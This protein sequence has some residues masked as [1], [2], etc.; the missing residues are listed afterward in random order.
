MDILDK[1][2]KNEESLPT[3]LIGIF[4]T[5]LG[6][7]LSLYLSL[8]T[9]APKI[10]YL[11]E[12][13]KDLIERGN[14]PKKLG[15]F[16]EGTDVIQQKK[17][18]RIY[19]IKMSNDGS[20]DLL[21]DHYDSNLPWGLSVHDGVIL[22]IR[23]V[24]SSSSYIYE[25]IKP[26][27]DVGREVML[28]KIIFERGNYYLFDLMVLHDI[29]AEPTLTP[30]GKIAGQKKIEIVTEENATNT[31]FF[32]WLKRIN[33][34]AKT[35]LFF[36]FFILS[37][38]VFCFL[39]WFYVLALPEH[40][41][42]RREKKAK[43]YFGQEFEI[44]LGFI[45]LPFSFKK[46]SD[47]FLQSVMFTLDLT[48]T[49]KISGF[50][51]RRNASAKGF[52]AG[53]Y[54]T[55]GKKGLK[56][57]AKELDKYGGLILNNIETYEGISRQIRKL[58]EEKDRLKMELKVDIKGEDTIEA[59]EKR[60]ADT[61]SQ[62]SPEIIEI[63]NKIAALEKTEIQIRKV[64]KGESVSETKSFNEVKGRYYRAHNYE[65]WGLLKHQGQ[66]YQW[67]EKFME[68]LPKFISHV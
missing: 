54:K 11:I 12:S 20:K 59:L 19:T 24:E 42:T 65:E 45:S 1:L 25:N 52:L 32:N 3:A 30:L 38:V 33:I 28:N 51:S 21:Q 68:L 46:S 44:P 67:D 8:L 58:Q 18:I 63:Q 35:L 22:E 9:T 55:F 27:S 14:T 48:D 10:T 26:R 56:R 7:G 16:F 36:L 66:E 4:L 41:K 49:S 23:P 57:L 61:K 31:G 53:V 6:I 17:N 34:I 2:K 43:S 40:L 15:V 29:K 64:E 50:N 5:V 39:L 37:G 13:K 62:E 47:F 60:I